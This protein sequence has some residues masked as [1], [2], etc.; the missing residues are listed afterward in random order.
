[1][2]ATPLQPDDL[3]VGTEGAPPRRVTR[4]DHWLPAAGLLRILAR[5]P[6]QHDGHGRP[7]APGLFIVARPRSHRCSSTRERDQRADPPGEPFQPPS[8][9]FPLGTDNFGRSVLDLVIYGSRISLL[10]GFAATVVTMHGRRRR[11]R[12]RLLRRADR[13]RAERLHELVP[14]DPVG[15][16]GHRAHLDPRAS[17]CQHHPR[18]RH[19]VVGGDGAARPRADALGQGTAVRRASSRARLQQLAPRH[20]GTSCPTS[21]R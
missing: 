13:H 19:H 16:A 20:A 10:V 17:L 3:T 15:P 11:D 6:P 9:E 2:I 1:M 7:R 18:D 14:R 4:A 12:R 8:L 21:C 5:L